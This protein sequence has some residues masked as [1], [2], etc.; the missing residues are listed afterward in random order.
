MLAVL[1]CLWARFTPEAL[2]EL[3]EVKTASTFRDIPEVEYLRKWMPFIYSIY[4]FL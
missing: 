2:A 1:R 3:N 4:K